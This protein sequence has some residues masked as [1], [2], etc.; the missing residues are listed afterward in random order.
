[1]VTC[2]QAKFKRKALKHGS[3]YY[4][5]SKEIVKLKSCYFTSLYVEYM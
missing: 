2:Y 4:C 1:M 5:P 3:A